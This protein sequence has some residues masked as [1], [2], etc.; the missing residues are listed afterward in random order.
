MKT[1]IKSI[2]LNTE[3]RHYEEYSDHHCIYDVFIITHCQLSNTK[4][5]GYDSYHHNIIYHIKDFFKPKYHN[6]KNN[7]F[8]NVKDLYKG[9]KYGLNSIYNQIRHNII[10]SKKRVYEYDLVGLAYGMNQTQPEYDSGVIWYMSLDEL[11]EDQSY[12]ED[13]FIIELES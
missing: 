1:K 9:L 11:F 8:L 4:P 7:S 5:M 10:V 13:L 3:S 6:N 12:Y 2:K